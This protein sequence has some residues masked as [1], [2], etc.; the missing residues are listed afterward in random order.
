MILDGFFVIFDRELR[1][2]FLVDDFIFVFKGD[3][4][5]LIFIDSFFCN[6]EDKVFVVFRFFFW[7]F[8]GGKLLVGEK[9]VRFVVVNFDEIF[10]ALEFIYNF[11]SLFLF[12]FFKFFVLILLV[13]DS[14]CTIFIILFFKCLFFLCLERI[15][16][17]MLG[18][19]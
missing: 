7:V 5:F 6:I 13:V 14:V 15:I 17:C 19:V 12:L 3:F 8:C 2:F 18:D 1:F 11:R 10:G 16:F 9:E 4:F